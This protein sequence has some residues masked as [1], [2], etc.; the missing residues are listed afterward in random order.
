MSDAKFNKLLDYETLK[1]QF[2]DDED[3]AQISSATSLL[4]TKKYTP[5]SSS[6]GNYID[7]QVIE[8]Y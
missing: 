8:F 3:K 2:G 4:F 1:Q 7:W 5:S 6:D